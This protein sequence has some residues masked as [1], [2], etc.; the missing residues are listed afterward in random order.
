MNFAIQATGLSKQYR[1]GASKTGATL[2]DLIVN[3]LEAPWR[4]TS[5]RAMPQEHATVWALRDVSFEV[6]Q[7][8]TLGILGH[9]GAGKS[10]LLRILSRITKPTSGRVRLR[11]RVGSL[12][13]VGAGFHTELS[14]RENILL[15]GVILGMKRREV[16]R[17]FD[18]IVAF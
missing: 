2:R 18:E 3:A 16:E 14:G 11:G 12:L 9:N 5:N 7:G 13:E 4:S 1:I 15:N 6:E 8:E 10:T 17:K